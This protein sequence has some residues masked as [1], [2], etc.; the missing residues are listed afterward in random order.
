VELIENR[1]AWAEHYNKNWLEHY[2]MTQEID[3][4]RYRYSRNKKTPSGSAIKLSH[5]KIL[6]ITSSGAYLKDRQEPFDAANDLGDYEIRKIPASVTFGELDY[7]HDHYDKT[8]VRQDSQV[9]LP[10]RHL[11]DLVIE[12]FIGGLT[13][14]FISFMGYQPDITKIADHLIPE[15][16]KKVKEQ[17]PDAVFLVPS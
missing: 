15:I 13:E 10:L 5:S 1:A 7:T 16:L 9:L 6:F 4:R 3:W 8:Q 2:H 11:E 17:Q 14:D 12:G